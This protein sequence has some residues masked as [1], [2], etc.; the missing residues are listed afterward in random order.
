MKIWVLTS[1]YNEYDQHGEYFIAAYKDKP[2]KLQVAA[3]LD[4]IGNPFH[5]V[6]EWAE[7]VLRGG[8][9]TQ[10]CENVWFHLEEIELK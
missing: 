5:T 6:E 3:E 2:T 4:N 10:N 9:R 7:H 1:E 8:G